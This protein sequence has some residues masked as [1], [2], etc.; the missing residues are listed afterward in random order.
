M[1]DGWLEAPF[2]LTGQRIWVA[3]HRGM[4]G[5]AL[6][7]RLKR[8]KCE[9]ITSDFDLC[10]QYKVDEFID[11][12]APD[13][14]IIAAARVG[15]ILANRD[16][17]AAFLYGN[18][19]I[20]ANIIHAAAMFGVKKLLFL[21]SSC[22]YPKDAVQP[23]KESALL[24]GALEPTNEA[25]AVA[26]IAGVK[27]CEAYRKQYGSDFISVMPCNLYGRNDRFD[28]ETSHV[29]PALMMK[30]HAAKMTGADTVEVWG[31]G[32]ALR[33]FMCVDDLADGL[34]FAL[35]HYSDARPLNIGS[36]A[37]VS[38]ADLARM[39]ADIVGYTGDLVFDPDMPDGV[40]R[41]VLDSSRLYDAGWRPSISLQDGLKQTY[42]WY[43]A[44]E[45]A[46]RSAG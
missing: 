25:Y 33:E 44:H 18:V 19:M 29:I 38:I 31:S 7:R 3:G 12:E 32:K 30:M 35:K 28:L 40:M 9:L 8:E 4:V 27:L 37:E 15:G 14:I 39:I 45:N 24:T 46:L 34:V 36:G 26:K 2:D 16:Y 11:I 42:Q 20:E 23:I 5:S 13:V 6:V 21:G 43:C 17:P 22:I 1:A 10:R 41:K